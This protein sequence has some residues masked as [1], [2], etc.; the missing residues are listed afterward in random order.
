MGDATRLFPDDDPI[1]VWSLL[2]LL[3][4]PTL[5][6]DMA[7]LHGEAL[8]LM[9]K[10]DAGNVTGRSWIHAEASMCR[11]AATAARADFYIT[12]CVRESSRSC[13]NLVLSVLPRH[14]PAWQATRATFGELDFV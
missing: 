9:L 12:I 6:V 8:K 11:A 7:Y 4:I 14:K 10:Q 2:G 3:M 13:T 1:L 5:Y